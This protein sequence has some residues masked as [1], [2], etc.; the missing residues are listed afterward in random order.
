MY[1]SSIFFHFCATINLVHKTIG[2]ILL[3]LFHKNETSKKIIHFYSI[4]S[5]LIFTDHL[6]CER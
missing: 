3:L 2:P 5:H 6:K 1:V 4:S